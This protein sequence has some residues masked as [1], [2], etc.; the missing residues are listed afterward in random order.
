MLKGIR[1]L[2]FFWMNYGL[3][4]S[5]VSPETDQP[6]LKKN[7]QAPKCKGTRDGVRTI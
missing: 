3:T 6:Y 2:N 4:I 1:M 5:C 7:F